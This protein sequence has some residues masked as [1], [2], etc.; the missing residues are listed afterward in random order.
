MAETETPRLAAPPRP[1]LAAPGW[2]PLGFARA[3]LLLAAMWMRAAW[4]Y[5]ASLTI[6]T[7]GQ[8]GASGLDFIAILLLFSHV[9]ALAGF[10]LTE[11]LF[12]YGT[13]AFSF[14]LSD[15]LLSSVEMLG[16]RIRSGAF[17]AMLVRPV[18]AL[19]QVCTDEFTPKRFGKVA[20][21]GAVLIVA[22]VRLRVVWT[23]ARVL[24]VALMIGCGTAIFGAVWVLQAAFQFVATDAREVMNTFTYGGQSLTQYPLA[25]YGRDAMRALTFAVPLAFVNWQPSLYVLG[26][27]D[28]LG[29]PLAFRFA[30]PAVALALAALAALCWR[31]GI[32]RYQSTGS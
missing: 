3:Y 11:V 18:S 17:D 23:P 15:L 2:R 30:S 6:M 12:L 21:S 4:Q 29:L 7:V 25:V 8:A 10:S 27:P 28:P 26:H 19:V 22:L 31:A 20:Q 16:D 14:G 13:A 5:R 32:R 1:E 24:V 9:S